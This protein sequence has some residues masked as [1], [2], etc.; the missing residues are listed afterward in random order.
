MKEKSSRE[1]AV[2]PLHLQSPTFFLSAKRVPNSASVIDP[3]SN[4]WSVWF[5]S[6]GRLTTIQI[7][8]VPQ[9]NSS[10]S[11][12]TSSD[13]MCPPTEESNG[14]ANGSTNGTNGNHEGFTG[15][16][17]RQNPHPAHRSPYQPVGDF[18]SNV[19]RFK[20]IGKM[21]YLS[22]PS[23]RAGNVSSK[24]FHRQSAQKPI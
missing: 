7:P 20:I 2:S 24:P 15:V 11:F 3:L 8:T 22:S 16:Q 12:L 13:N 6:L 10:S 18:L 21:Q 5:D 4:F 1:G 23:R 14:P 19:S 9:P 17:T